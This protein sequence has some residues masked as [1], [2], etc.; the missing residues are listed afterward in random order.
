MKHLPLENNGRP[1]VG[2]VLRNAD[3]KFKPPALVVPD[4]Q[5]HQAMPHEV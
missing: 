5:A 3:P 1:T 4:A 2:V